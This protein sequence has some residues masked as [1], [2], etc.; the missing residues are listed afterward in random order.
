MYLP[1]IFKEKNKSQISAGL[2]SLVTYSLTIK[3]NAAAGIFVCLLV[4]FNLKAFLT[5]KQ[6]VDANF[7]PFLTTFKGKNRLINHSLFCGFYYI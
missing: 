4:L 6:N 2:Q 5:I 3:K 1:H 7:M